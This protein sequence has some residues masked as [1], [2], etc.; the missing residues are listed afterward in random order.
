MRSWSH[1]VVAA[2][3]LLTACRA[4][5]PERLSIKDAPAA[6]QRSI[7]PEWCH[8]RYRDHSEGRQIAESVEE[9]EK[10]DEAC[11]LQ[12]CPT[13]PKNVTYST[14]IQLAARRPA[15]EAPPP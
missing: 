2:A 10:H 6:P 3:L 5:I 7:T 4:E 12:I 15:T 9:K 14:L 13:C 8:K 11:R 1:V